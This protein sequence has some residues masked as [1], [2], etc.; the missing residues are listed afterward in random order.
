MLHELATN[1]AKYGAL[2][3]PAG[4]VGISWEI[5]TSKIAPSKIAGGRSLDLRWNEVGGPPVGQPARKGFGSRL[6]DMG[7]T[8]LEGEIDLD[9]AAAGLRCRLRFPLDGA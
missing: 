5:V 3:M 4:R 7:A 1:A 2:S 8:Q 9:Y 6:L